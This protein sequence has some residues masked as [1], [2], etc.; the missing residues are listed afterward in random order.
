LPFLHRLSPP[1]GLYLKRQEH[2]QKTRTEKMGELHALSASDLGIR[3]G[4]RSGDCARIGAG[5]ARRAR[6][7]AP[8]TIERESLGQFP[9]APGARR[10]ITAF[11]VDLDDDGNHEVIG[12][13]ERLSTKQGDAAL[14]TDPE[15]ASS[16]GCPSQ[17]STNAYTCLF[18]QPLRIHAR[19][20]RSCNASCL[21]GTRPASDLCACAGKEDSFHD[22]G[23]QRRALPAIS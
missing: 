23:N 19:R 11:P 10:V 5:G 18:L 21:A 9:P 17:C 1:E 6:G 8:L 4:L 13:R 15:T 14:W 16:R 7:H 20:G 3:G 2:S 22:D 12:I